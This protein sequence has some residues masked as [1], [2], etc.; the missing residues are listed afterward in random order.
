M[1][2]FLKNNQSIS[3]ALISANPYD[4]IFLENKTYHEKIKINL[5]GVKIIGHPKGSVIEY[6]DHYNT[7]DEN[8]FELMTVRTYTVMVA[9]DDV[10][11]TDLTIKNLSVP[12]QKYG[13]A[14]ALHVLGD[15]FTCNNCQMLGAQDTLLCGPIPY[16]LTIRYKDILPLDELT[17]RKS[18]QHYINCYIEGDVDFIF[19]CGI[20]IFENCHI[21]SIGK[22]YVSAPS[23]PQEYKY[24]FTFINCKITSV[25]N[26]KGQ[27]FLS[28]PWRDYGTATFINCECGEHINGT[29]F[30]NWQK[31]R[32]NT[33]R[34]KIYNCLDTK[35]MVSFAK[36][37]SEDELSLYTVDKIKLS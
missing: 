37:L 16:D 15:N 12:S 31:S 34:F 4:T 3:S 25:P 33:C 24:G 28:R 5:K 11:L 1:D 23:H 22:G 29:I 7:I 2:I 19:G 18:H 26:I 27:V 17:Q 10:V 14:V 20:S 8:N 6:N 13:Q 9:A 36:T 35:N 30:N 32:E 21:H